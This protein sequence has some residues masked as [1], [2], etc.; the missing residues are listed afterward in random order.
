MSPF[1]AAPICSA[2]LD[3]SLWNLGSGSMYWRELEKYPLKRRAYQVVIEL[4]RPERIENPQDVEE[5]RLRPVLQ[6]NAVSS[7]RTAYKGIAT[8]RVVA[9]I[10]TCREVGGEDSR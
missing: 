4:D 9:E 5:V 3:R 7:A 8:P 2:L 6:D 10:T 1:A